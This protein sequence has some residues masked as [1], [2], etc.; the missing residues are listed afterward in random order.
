[1]FS[2]EFA[3]KRP[4]IKNIVPA[5][6]PLTTPALSRVLG[7]ICRGLIALWRVRRSERECGLQQPRKIP[8]NP[9]KLPGFD[10]SPRC[11]D[12]FYIAAN[13]QCSRERKGP[14]S[15]AAKHAHCRNNCYGGGWQIVT[16]KVTRSIF[17][18]HSAQHRQTERSFQPDD[19][20]S[21]KLSWYP[22]LGRPSARAFHD[23]SQLRRCSCRLGWQ[24]TLSKKEEQ[25]VPREGSKS[26][27]SSFFW[28]TKK[29]RKVLKVSKS[30]EQ[31]K[32]RQT[33]F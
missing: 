27:F 8:S 16:L 10:Q 9:R 5:E 33:T 18:R 30:P 19:D 17:A 7:S 3:R 24:R 13:W 28:W 20:A 4:R 26:G 25:E 21:G 29:V 1:M 32:R 6:R 22:M 14:Q 23:N 11:L 15:H 2:C 31:P 12:R